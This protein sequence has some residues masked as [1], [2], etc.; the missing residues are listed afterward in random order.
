M[1]RV[2][3]VLLAACGE[4]V[5]PG[6]MVC[7]ADDG[8]EVVT[9]PAGN[10]GAEVGAL[11]DPT[12]T[13]A[14]GL[15]W[16]GPGPIAWWTHN[17]S[18]DAAVL[19]GLSSVGEVLARVTLDGVNPKDLEDL[20]RRAVDGGIELWLGD[21]GDN[22]AKRDDVEVHRVVV[23]ADVDG[24]LTLEADD[25]TWIY[26]D[27]PRDAEAMFVDPTDGSAWV[28]DK[29]RD[30]ALAT[31]LYHA[32]AGG[33]GS[34]TLTRE[35]DLRFGEG[36]LAGADL[37]VTGADMSPD[38]AWIV[39][40]TYQTAFVWPRGEAQSVPEAMAEAPCRV[41]LIDEPQGEAVAFD[42]AGFVTVSE[43]AGAALYRYAWPPP[44]EAARRASR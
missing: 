28:L 32:P 17:D 24:D 10:F 1:R 13:E 8:G 43:G 23:P 21:I 39:V 42:D 44:D 15:A 4:E 37:L 2:A 5:K 22:G 16:G 12:I 20:G 29:I 41:E 6:C 27:G 14:S 26:E 34:Q 31:G 33:G 36:V 40:R 19:F 18:G 3:L 9:C 7:P 11:G 25:T 35:L 38:G 30:A